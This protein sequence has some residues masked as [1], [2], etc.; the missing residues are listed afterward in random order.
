MADGGGD[1]FVVGGDKDAFDRFGGLNAP[2]DVFDQRFTFDFDDG[3]SGETCGLESC[4]DDRYGSFRFH[5][6]YIFWRK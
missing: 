6:G 4:R 2:V 5:T 3:L 1:A